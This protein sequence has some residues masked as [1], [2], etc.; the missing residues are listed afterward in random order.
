MIDIKKSD[1]SIFDYTPMQED[2]NNQEI[3]KILKENLIKGK[4]MR[5]VSEL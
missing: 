2:A 3:N 1:A 5:L 4:R